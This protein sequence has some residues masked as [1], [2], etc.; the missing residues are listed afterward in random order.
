M[1]NRILSITA[2][3]LRGLPDRMGA[4]TVIVVGLA[5]VVG[6]LTALLAMNEGLSHT[7]TS[8]GSADR[9]LVLR[10]GSNAELNS[11]FDKDNATL[12][13]EMPG[14]KKGADGRPL[15]SRE[16][17]LIA[18]LPLKRSGTSG[19][20]TLRGVESTA[21]ELRGG[22]KI[23]AGRPFEP[24]RNE[25]IVGSQVPGQFDGAELGATLR[26]RGGDWTVVGVFEAGNAHDSE[27]WLDAAT[28]Q[29]AFNRAG[30]S[31]VLVALESPAAI[32]TLKA[33]LEA[34][35]RL[36]VDAIAQDQFYERQT[37]SSTGMIRALA[38][39]VTIVMAMGA[40]FAA[41]NTMYASVSARGREIAT[42]RALGFG[43]FPVVASVLVESMVLALI[44]GLI[45][46]AIAWA[47]FDNLSVTTLGANFT[48]VVFGFKVS[49]AIVGTGLALALMVG[50]VGGLLPA[51]RAAR[52]PVAT[53]LRGA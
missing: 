34:D 16:L 38:Y 25:V 20:V 12:I 30:Y 43:A 10:S 22:V 53:A 9:A 51:I 33:A 1:I 50:F 14:I 31:S 44:G 6:V 29:D 36:R 32:E 11:G 21:F 2:M 13:T 52:A 7:L 49:G 42:L 26:I 4:S 45:G 24:G 15:A 23:V 8:T 37:A 35:P 27:L 19:N 28:A 39:L 3:N 40:V 5:G 47:L 46:A 18:E 48:Q 41:L 17:M